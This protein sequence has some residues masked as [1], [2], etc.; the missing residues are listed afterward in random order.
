MTAKPRNIYD[1]LDRMFGLEKV[2]GPDNTSVERYASITKLPPMLHFFFQKHHFDKTV[3]KSVVTE[4]EGELNDTIYMDRYMADA[5]NELAA[6]RE[7]SRRLTRDLEKYKNK[8]TFSTK[9]K[10]GM[11]RIEA[12]DQTWQFISD[13]GEDLG[14][15]ADA[16]DVESLKKDL[17]AEEERCKLAVE[18]VEQRIKDLEAQRSALPFEKFDTEGNKYRL[19]ASMVHLGGDNIGHYVLIMRDFATGIWREYNDETVKEVPGITAGR[20][21][22]YVVYVRDDVKDDMVQPIH[23]VQPP[24]VVEEEQDEEMLQ[25]KGEDEQ[26][27]LAGNADDDTLMFDMDDTEMP[28]LIEIDGVDPTLAYHG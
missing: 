25:Q 14:E 16:D 5:S 24:A 12:L 23:R 7:E 4:W 27:L 1:A 11:T 13:L 20:P 28:E 17:K 9:K 3:G 19:F 8:Q 18:E 10:A 2:P 6:L 15:A 26:P 22:Y 21:P